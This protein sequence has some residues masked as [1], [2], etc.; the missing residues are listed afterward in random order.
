M[1]ELSPLQQHRQWHCSGG[2][3]NLQPAIHLA[4]FVPILPKLLLFVKIASFLPSNERDMAGRRWGYRQEDTKWMKLSHK[5][6]P[7]LSK[8]VRAVMELERKSWAGQTKTEDKK[9]LQD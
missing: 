4:N 7:V 6:C 9:L 1:K 3:R 8:S 2:A 5:S